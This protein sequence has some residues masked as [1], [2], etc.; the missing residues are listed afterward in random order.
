LTAPA[1]RDVERYRADIADFYELDVGARF[2]H[3]ARNLVTED[4]SFGSSRAPTNHM[5]VASAN[6]RGND[7]EDYA[8]IEFAIAERELR[9]IDRLNFN[10]TGTGIDDAAIFSHAV[11]FSDRSEL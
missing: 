11:L 6:I 9:K 1:A 2:D 5:L 4:N 3:F 7:L 8:V 10:L